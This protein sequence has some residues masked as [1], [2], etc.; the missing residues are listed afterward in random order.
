MDTRPRVTPQTD[1]EFNDVSFGANYDR[2]APETML[3]RSVKLRDLRK[4]FN[5]GRGEFVAVKGV[6][7]DM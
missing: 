1:E 5:T 7:Y 3:R 2:V 6:T 4:V